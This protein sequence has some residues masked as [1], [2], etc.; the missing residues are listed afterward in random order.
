MAPARAAPAAPAAPAAREAAGAGAQRPAGGGVAPPAAAGAAPPREGGGGAA[1]APAPP[2]VNP[3][4]HI[5]QFHKALRRDLRSLEAEARAFAAALD[6]AEDWRGGGAALQALEGR[7]RFLW[8]IYCAHSEAEDAIVFPALEAKE[9]LRYVSHAYTLDHQQEAQLFEEMAAVLRR[10]AGAA[11]LA[12]AR[13]A[14]AA[15]ARLTAATRASL[16]Q[17]VRAEE[18]ELWPLFAENFT[19]AEQQH[20]VGVIV[21]RT[22][23]EVLQAM[24]P[25]VTGSCTADEQAAM[26]ASLRSAT[27][28]T[29]F[30]RW[31]GATLP[32]PPGAAAGAPGGGPA[33][34]PAAAA[35]AAPAAAPPH[36]ALDDVADYLRGGG[37]GG[38]GASLDAGS[39][40][41][42]G[43]GGGGAA[44]AEAGVFRPGWEDIFRMNQ[45]QLEARPAPERP[46][47]CSLSP[48][49]SGGAQQ[50][51]RPKSVR[52]SRV[53]RSAGSGCRPACQQPAGAPGARM[54]PR[55]A[56]AAPAAASP[57][58]AG[59]VPPKW[60]AGR[61]RTPA[62]SP[63]FGPRAG[64]GAARVR[65]RGPGRGA[66]GVPDAEHHGLALHRRA[67][68]PPG[69]QRRR[70]RRRRRPGRRPGA[71]VPRRRARRARLRALPAPLP[72]GRALL[73]PGARVPLLPR[74]GGRPP[75]GPARR[76]R[77]GLHGLQ[78]APAG[79]GRLPVVR[80]G[81]GALL[82][83][84][85]PPVGRRA[86][87]RHLPLPLLQPVPARARPGRRRVP[88]HGLQLLHAPGRVR[89]AQVPRPERV[90]GLHGLPVRLGAALPG[91]PPA[92]PPPLRSACGAARCVALRCAALS[93]CGPLAAARWQ[94]WCMQY[95]RCL[96]PAACRLLHAP[97]A[98]CDG[99]LFRSGV[100]AALR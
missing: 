41:G 34:A 7:Y 5:F 58:S 1:A 30:E 38:A 96:L 93:S 27:R 50:A 23:A 40:S 32:P 98:G 65:R 8:G 35:A 71:H 3:I 90:P 54:R 9:A 60:S 61:R 19:E 59:S 33:G 31:L 46:M 55:A 24:L 57:K 44:G 45:Q 48:S 47:A 72:R 25:W 49:P 70:R 97:S 10:V 69:R 62:P 95:A 11:T 89:A 20:L 18:Q 73:R 37:G 63:R 2:R 36:L 53:G 81:D 15:L 68:A 28:N 86:R 80:A 12:D 52:A 16:E 99:R 77:H 94:S 56:R 66:Q 14:A 92:P 91:A 26:M 43:G 39:G 88:L 6:E 29:G 100:G 84:H 13:G 64:D 75:A 82:L 42:V 22:G 85:L 21:G 67:A 4:D 87:A 79:R 74:R 17:H 83:R 78:R 51:W 76:H